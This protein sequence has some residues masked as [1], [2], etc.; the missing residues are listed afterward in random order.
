MLLIYIVGLITNMFVVGYYFN[1]MEDSPTQ[2][3][4]NAS[5][6]FIAMGPYTY[7]ITLLYIVVTWLYDRGRE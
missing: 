6:I 5:V 7:L 2:D 4:I 1:E 3:E